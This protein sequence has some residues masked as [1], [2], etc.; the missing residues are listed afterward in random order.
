MTW[1]IFPAQAPEIWKTDLRSEL[2][3]VEL[4]PAELCCHVVIGRVVLSVFVCPIV[5]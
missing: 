4:S 2:C 1:A 5:L 3:R